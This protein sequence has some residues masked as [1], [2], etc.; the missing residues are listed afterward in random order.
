MMG[1]AKRR[2]KLILMDF[3]IDRFGEI[4]GLGWE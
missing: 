3:I 4:A 1:R 2:K